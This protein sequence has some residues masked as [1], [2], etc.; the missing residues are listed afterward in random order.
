MTSLPYSAPR[1]KKTKRATLLQFDTTMDPALPEGAE[2]LSLSYILIHR[3]LGPDPYREL[4]ALLEGYEL[5]DIRGLYYWKDRMR[6]YV[7][8]VDQL[9]LLIASQLDEKRNFTSFMLTAITTVLAPLTIFTGYF[10]MN[11]ENMKELDP[12]TYP[13]TP[14]VVVLWAICGLAYA[15]LLVL[16]IH[17]RVLYSVS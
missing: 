10:G 16:G 5:L 17:F 1:T 3:F 4:R 12:E 14:G 9:K 2:K 6:K 13:S 7:V 15:T 11:F 8:K